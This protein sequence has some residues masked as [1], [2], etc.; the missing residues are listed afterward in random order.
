[1]SE[2]LRMNR[3]RTVSRDRHNRFISK[4]CLQTHPMT[5]FADT[6]CEY[7]TIPVGNPLKNNKTFSRGKI[8]LGMSK[9]SRPKSLNAFLRGLPTGIV[10]LYHTKDSFPIHCTQNSC[11]CLLRDI[12]IHLQTPTSSERNSPRQIR[13]VTKDTVTGGI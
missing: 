5:G 1:M 6:Y 2:V 8:L 7:I 9:K 11:L 3:N 12:L 10:L 13:Y 4:C